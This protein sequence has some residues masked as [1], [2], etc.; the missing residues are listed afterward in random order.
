MQLKLWKVDISAQEKSQKQKPNGEKFS[1]SSGETFHKQTLHELAENFNT[2]AKNG[3]N[4]VVATQLFH[5][6]GPNKIRQRGENLF[7]KILSYFFAGFG[8]LF[9]VAAILCILAWR[10]LGA[11]DGNTP[12]PI[13]L[14]LGV[15]LVVVIF[16]QAGFNAFQDWSS[17][18][19][20]KSIKNMMPSNADVIRSGKEVIF[21]FIL[22]FLK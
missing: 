15:M 4:S 17:T 10:P 14:S 1:C 19:V 2:C 22:L 8:S 16:I 3:L 11:L 18:R 12:D 21:T 5:K 6:N 13:N 9:F 7:L 20:M